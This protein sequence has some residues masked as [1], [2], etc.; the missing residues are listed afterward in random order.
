MEPAA[1]LLFVT[2]S[3]GVRL[4]AQKL[5]FSDLLLSGELDVVTGETL[6]S[7]TRGCNPSVGISKVIGQ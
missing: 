6:Q 5:K 2:V 7:H 1:I 4:P 3:W